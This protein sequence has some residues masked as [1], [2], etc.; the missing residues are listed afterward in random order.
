MDKIRTVGIIPN[1]LK[2]VDFSCTD[3]M[4]SK[5]CS[6]GVKCLLPEE[7]NEHKNAKR[8]S[9]DELYGSS[10]CLI[11]LGGDGTILR[12]S[13]NAAKYN[14]PILG[15]NIGTIGF[16]CELYPDEYDELEKLA[17][18]EYD[19]EKRYMLDVSVI[20]NGKC[21]GSYTAL[22]DAVIE[23]EGISKVIAIELYRDDKRIID[24]MANGLI[25]S[26]PTGSTAYSLAAGGPIVDPA[27]C[28]TTVTP[29]CP[30]TLTE[31]PMIFDMNARLSC[32]ISS[33]RGGLPCLNVDG[34]EYLSLKEG[35][36]VRVTKSESFTR[37]IRL[38]KLEF[39]DIIYQKLS[40]KV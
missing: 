36:I 31:K 29:I 5:L 10:E 11:I 26:T 38:K 14:I 27:T 7:C 35:D 25:V 19:I 39:Y 8:V 4:I 16:I 22:N 34:R 9:Y 40:I 28:V 17:I 33:S 30:H 6:C 18:G 13:S 37:L 24:Y 1:P 20:R 21:I 32:K 23:S 12:H 3:K 2:D 15:V